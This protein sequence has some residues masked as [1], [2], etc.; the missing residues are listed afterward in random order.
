[1]AGMGG[2]INYPII[3][4]IA[5]ISM[6]RWWNH[7][8]SSPWPGG[9]WINSR[10]PANSEPG[11]YYPPS[12]GTLRFQSC[13]QSHTQTCI[14][15]AGLANQGPYP[16]GP[17][18]QML[19]SNNNDNGNNNLLSDNLDNQSQFDSRSH[20]I[21]RATVS[22]FPSVSLSSLALENGCA[23]PGF[24]S[25]KNTGNPLGLGN[26]PGM[27]NFPGIRKPPD[28]GILPDMENSAGMGNAPGMG[29]L[30][31][32][33][34]PLDMENLLGQGFQDLMPP[35]A[36]INFSAPSSTV[37]K[38]QDTLLSSVSDTVRCEAHGI[39]QP[40]S[41]IENPPLK[42]RTLGSNTFLCTFGGCGVYFTR[43]SDLR[44]HHANKHARINNFFC[45]FPFCERCTRG[46]PRKDKRDEHERKVHPNPG[47]MQ[48]QL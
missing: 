26:S 24:R 23:S 35:P 1:M 5:L 10:L 22:P 42:F 15:Y 34:N 39:H 2:D 19:F 21:S 13:S 41:L 18:Y 3:W 31:G 43:I 11:R 8:G 14:S 27:G 16:N 33:G 47:W 7:S 30:L 40:K 45:R 44:R 36:N 29:N 25:T 17:S 9:A 38:S 32:I 48:P 4:F 12:I 20:M 37:L 6:F 46:F 28:M